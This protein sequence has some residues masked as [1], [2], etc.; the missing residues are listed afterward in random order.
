MRNL[1]FTLAVVL[2][3]MQ[4]LTGVD[5][6]LEGDDILNE[7]SIK[8]V[9]AEVKND[10]NSV[11]IF[12]DTLYMMAEREGYFEADIDIAFDDYSV[13]KI[14]IESGPLYKFGSV[15]ISL[16]GSALQEAEIELESEF[17]N[18]PATSE[19]IQALLT[20]SVDIFADNGF[21]F[22][23]SKIESLEKSDFFVD[24]ALEITSGPF[25]QIDSL[26]FQSEKN[27]SADFMK[28]KSGLEQGMPF[29]QT[30]VEN[31]IARINSL[32]YMQ[33]EGPPDE[34]FYNNYNSCLL[35][36]DIEQRGLNR[37]E[38]AL[39]YNPGTEQVDGFVFGFLD[40][41][42][43]NP[44]GDGKNFFI[45]WNK[46][47]ETSSRIRL[48][49]EYPYPLGIPFE[50][51]YEIAQEKFRDLYLSLNAEANISQTF[52]LNDKLNAGLKWTKVTAQG[53]SFRSIFDSRV[54]QASVGIALS[55]FDDRDFDLS[56]R[57]F[58]VRL[59]YIHKRLYRTKG[60]TPDDNSFN[61]FKAELG[62]RLGLQISQLFF[63]DMKASF[64]GFSEDESLISAAEMIKL[65]GRETLRGYSE[66]QFITTRAGWV[67]LEFGVYQKS[68]LKGFIFADLGYARLS[69]I[70]SSTDEPSFDDEFLFGAGFGFHL[71]SG[72]TGLDL[73][74]GWSKDDSFSEGKLYLILDNRF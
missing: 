59:S 57:S 7:K 46:P 10:S 42:F 74:I 35:E 23:Q 15:D 8:G 24:V 1:I 32:D 61:P 51:S 31:S 6:L 13:M 55:S 62:F 36:Y 72:Q 5:I 29:S 71:F 43:Y 73:N 44:F 34:K 11:V 41:S 63:A 12:E 26:M 45:K 27:L 68:Q 66:E 38:G 65:G 14:K 3:F 48:S 20:K 37:L 58:D 50:T 19:N 53:E 54:Y 30:E 22:A 33:I 21:P 17:V 70:Y 2:A 9:W 4:T 18:R 28:R 52:S 49:F 16:I 56:G 47:G 69:D 64:E 67:N 25:V 60:E 40:L 39:G